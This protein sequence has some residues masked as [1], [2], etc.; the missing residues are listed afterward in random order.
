MRPS[1][2]ARLLQIGLVLGPAMVVLGAGWLGTAP[3][4][5]QASD[6]E[7]PGLVHPELPST[8]PSATP[9]QQAALAWFST[10]PAIPVQAFPFVKTTDNKDHQAQNA[11]GETARDS[12]DS[13]VQGLIITGMMKTP[14]GNVAS[15][16]KRVYRVGEAV[17]DGLVISVIDVDAGKVELSDAEGQRYELIWNPW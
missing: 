5:A 11:H 4:G 10:R 2:S 1:P 8:A 7:M 17:R 3:A 14:T 13:P 15:I 6:A 9:E 12:G 16:G